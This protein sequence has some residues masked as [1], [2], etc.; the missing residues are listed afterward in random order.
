M[1][2]PRFIVWREQDRRHL[3]LMVLL[4]VALGMLVT[5]FFIVCR[6]VRVEGDSMYP[7]LLPGDR[8]LVTRGYGDPTPGDIV[9]VTVTDRGKRV[10]VL[11]RV[12]ALPGDTVS[13]AGDVAY[14]NGAPSYVAP[15]AIIGA[16][17]RV[18]DPFVVPEGTI[19]V[20]GDNRPVSLDSRFI[21]PVPLED[22]EGRV[23]VVL[24]PVTRFQVIDS[25]R[26]SP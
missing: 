16:D 11:K 24:M 17:A 3:L 8:V 1:E 18:I 19:I 21:G 9:S 22:V 13:F 6:V 10:G 12:V 25:C 2:R 7:A 14:V 26:V 5:L 15:Q 23:G 4:A 20:L